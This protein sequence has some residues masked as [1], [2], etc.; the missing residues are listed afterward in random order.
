MPL[1]QVRELLPP[2]YRARGPK[3]LGDWLRLLR[4]GLPGDGLARLLDSLGISQG[5][6]CSALD[7]PERTLTRRL[8]EGRLSP[9]E[10]GKVLRLARIWERANHVFESEVAARDWMKTANPTLE[11]A[12]PLSLLHA[13]IGAEAVLDV[14]GRIEHGV[15]S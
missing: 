5:E 9:D 6:L 4:E 12:A 13:D 2:G 14:L 11:G 15:F 1:Y 3:T 7:I 10:S 8:R